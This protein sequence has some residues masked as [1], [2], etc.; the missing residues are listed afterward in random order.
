MAALRL[1]FRLP[2]SL[3][4]AGT[5]NVSPAL[6]QNLAQGIDPTVTQTGGTQNITPAL[7]QQLTAAFDPTVERETLGLVGWGIP[8]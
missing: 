4:P 2:T 1:P 3:N 5:Q 8:L 7:H 6:H